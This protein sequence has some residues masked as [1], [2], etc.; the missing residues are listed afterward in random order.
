MRARWPMLVAGAMGVTAL[1]GCL[2]EP[3]VDR[4]GPDGIEM[5][6]YTADSSIDAAMAEAEAYCRPLGKHALLTREFEDQ[7]VTTA[8][9][10]CR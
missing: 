10:A 2:Q 3:R 4:S 9:F 5:H 7:D 6:W 1:S 8:H